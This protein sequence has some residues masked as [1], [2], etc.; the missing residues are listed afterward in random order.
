MPLLLETTQNSFNHTKLYFTETTP[1]SI[2]TV[3]IS[4]RSSLGCCQTCLAD[5]F[6]SPNRCKNSHPSQRC[7]RPS[8]FDYPDPSSAQPGKK[9]LVRPASQQHRKVELK[10]NNQRNRQGISFNSP[11]VKPGLNANEWLSSK[12][13]R[14]FSQ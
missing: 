14:F 12:M 2:I 6:T 5:L 1:A 4:L 13:Q 10:T 11:D 3:K 8:A 9:Q 7:K